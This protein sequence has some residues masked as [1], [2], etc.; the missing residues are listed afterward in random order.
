[1]QNEDEAAAP[2]QSQSVGNIVALLKR[3]H[4]ARLRHSLAERFI[5]RATTSL[6]TIWSVYLHLLLFGLWVLAARGLLPIR[7][8]DPEL[9]ILALIL[10]LESIFIATFV[11]IAQKRMQDLAEMRA[12]LTL[13]ISLLEERENTRLMHLIT[14]ISDKLGISIHEDEELAE[15]MQDVDPEKLLGEIEAGSSGSKT[16]A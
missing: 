12:N 7:G 1:M 9:R 2:G 8:F 13:H 5:A 10:A 15:L 3:R 16:R 6:A 4:D 14:R 11:L